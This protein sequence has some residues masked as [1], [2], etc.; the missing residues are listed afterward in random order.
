M[1]AERSR[2]L[3]SAAF[4][5][6]LVAITVVIA[7]MLGSVGAQSGD[8]ALGTWK[9][10]LAK[11]KYNPGPAP[12]STTV[13]YSVAGQGLK[14]VV[15]TVGPDGV[16]GHWEYTANFD[17][18]D[19]PMIGNNADADSASLKRINANTVEVVNK[20]GGKRTLTHT[21]VLSADGKTLTITS[22]GTNAQGQTVNNVQVFEKG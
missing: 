21:R 18:K 17:G 20:R 9:I 10:N 12:K 8:P 7:I 5:S 16:K 6:L 3:A 15:D 14:V 19:Y 4:T 1:N 11:S 13:T 22:T 2:I